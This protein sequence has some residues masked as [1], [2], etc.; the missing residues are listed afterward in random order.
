MGMGSIALRQMRCILIVGCIFGASSAN[1][2]SNPL[3]SLAWQRGP[4]QGQI[5]EK[6]AIQVPAGYV[7]LDAANTKKWN[8]I[9]QEIGSSDQYL[10]APQDLSWSVYFRFAPVGYVKD[11]N[12]IDAPALLETVKQGTQAAN[13]ERRRRGWGTL[14]V[15]GWQALPY[16]D[17]Q[18]KLLE[19]S[20]AGQEDT[21]QRPIVNYNTRILGRTGVMSVTLVTSPGVCQPTCRVTSSCLL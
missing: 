7:F 12:D 6:A 18:R 16:Y 4:I 8:E 17:T 14:T 10:F 5:G 20:F 9:N 15:T 2:Q 21:T 19:W 13:E 3:A 1:A 11:E